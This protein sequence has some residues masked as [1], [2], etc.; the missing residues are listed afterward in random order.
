MRE[1]IASAAIEGVAITAA[2]QE[3]FD[4]YVRG[5]IED[6]EMIDRVLAIY[7]PGC[8]R[9][10]RRETGRAA[11]WPEDHKAI[12]AGAGHSGAAPGVDV[13]FRCFC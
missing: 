8:R 10:E 2:T 12:R 11:G 5:S 4:D 9:R 13:R 7:G 6:G 3:I 1:A